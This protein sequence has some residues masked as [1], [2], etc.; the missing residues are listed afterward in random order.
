MVVLTV[1]CPHH[2]VPVMERILFAETTTFGV[3]RHSVARVKMRRRHETVTTPY[4]DVQMKVG[5]RSGVG[6]RGRVAAEPEA[7]LLDRAVQDGHAEDADEDDQHP[8]EERNDRHPVAPR[9]SQ[10]RGQR[11]PR[12][13]QEFD[14]RDIYH[15]P[16]RNPEREAE[17]SPVRA[18]REKSPSADVE[19]LVRLVLRD[20]VG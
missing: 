18:A 13:P 1:L 2:Q 7:D 10:F 19:E 17:Q 11:F 14:H 6:P 3:R 9:C 15:H 20:S 16:G 4:G 5:E 8:A 12:S